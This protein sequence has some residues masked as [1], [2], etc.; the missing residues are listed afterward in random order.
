[1][2]S[3]AN[4]S[5]HLALWHVLR[6]ILGE[7]QMTMMHS[8]YSILFIAQFSSCP[9]SFVI[10]LTVI[11]SQPRLA[12]ANNKDRAVTT[13]VEIGTPGKTLSLAYGRAP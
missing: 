11:T 5:M 2:V 13:L 3:D 1:M 9:L 7:M 8:S 10:F 12:C 6:H 4:I